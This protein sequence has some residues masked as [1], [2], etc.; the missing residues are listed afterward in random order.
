MLLRLIKRELHRLTSRKIYIFM[1]LIV[2]LGCSFFLLNLM[3]EGLPLK[4]P[5]GMVDLDHSSLSRKVGRSLSASELIDISSDL[6]DFHSAMEKVRSGEIYGFFLIPRDFQKKA[7]GGSTP[8]LSF[9][10]NM[11]IFVPGSLSYKGFKTIAVTTSGGIVKTT[12][13]G[14]GADEATAGSLIQPMVIRT[15]PLNNPWTNY[16]I[17]LCQSFISCL[18]AL[19]VLLVTVFSI[20]QE[21]K[22]GSSVEWLREAGGNMAMALLGKLLPQTLIFTAVGVAL[23]SVMFGYLHFP[24][25]NHPLHMILAMFLLVAACQGFAVFIT[26][27]LPN[28]R[29]ALSVMSLTGILCFSIA[30]FS[31][32]VE[33]MYGGVAIFSYLVPIRYY[34]LIYIDQ[35]LN[36]IPIYY[37][38]FYY[39]ALLI[40][41]LLPALGLRRL[42]KQ[43]I[44][45]V[46]V[47]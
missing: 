22:T 34:F 46:Y 16:A 10:S 6:E 3:N 44:N 14:A 25:N 18:L 40:F 32:P 12:L 27:M 43:C 21:H 7:I 39:I 31:F 13:V 24:L 29:I 15:H 19:I 41:M 38:R 36:G 20:C 5:V 2:P 47:P 23:Q 28:L 45:P 42:K 30:G 37:S 35:A 11:A 8:T 4:V 33:K 1:M 9:Y 26:E 17:Y